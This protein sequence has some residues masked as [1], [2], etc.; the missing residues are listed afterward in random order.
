MDAS[1]GLG[2]PGAGAVEAAAWQSSQARL[3]LPQRRAPM[4]EAQAAGL[5]KEFE[6]QFITQM[7]GLMFE[8]VSTDHAF[9]GG[10]A[11]EIYR[12]FLMDEYG[13]IFAEAGGIGV[14]D[15]VR[16]ELLKMQE[17]KP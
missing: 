5:A 13:K 6:A 16:T 2:A 3:A 17:V 15:H 12:S 11:E 8:G 14:A 4:N 9:G 7:L 10:P 1:L